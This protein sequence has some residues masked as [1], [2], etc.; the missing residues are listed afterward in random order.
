MGVYALGERSRRNYDTAR[1]AKPRGRY[2]NSWGIFLLARTCPC[3][4]EFITRGSRKMNADRDADGLFSSALPLTR[5]DSAL[6]RSLFTTYEMGKPWDK[7]RR[8]VHLNRLVSNSLQ[9]LPF[10]E[11]RYHFY[12]GTNLLRAWPAILCAS[13]PCYEHHAP[14]MS[15]TPLLWTSRPCYERDHSCAAWLH[16]IARAGCLSSYDFPSNKKQFALANMIHVV[17]AILHSQVHATYTR[18]HYIYSPFNNCPIIPVFICMLLGIN[19]CR[20]YAGILD[21]SLNEGYSRASFKRCCFQSHVT[22]A[23]SFWKGGC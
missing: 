11:P 1:G 8:T 4:N 14:A 9:Q 3:I 23:N 2:H 19:Y 18:L 20:I 22:T 5:S 12:A 13:R 10:Q 21:L 7:R 15:I 17:V 16:K 6:S